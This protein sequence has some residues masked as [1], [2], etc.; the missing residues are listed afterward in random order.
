[1]TT[2]KKTISLV[3]V[4]GGA[5]TTRL[6]VE[7]AATLARAGRSV[8]VIDADTT[9]QGL[10]DYVPGEINPD[11]TRVFAD[12]D[13]LEDALRSL[14]LDT[15]G[16]VAVA[17]AHAPFERLARAQTAGAAQSLGDALA[18]AARDYDHV[19]VDTPA[20]ATNLA[21]AA[22]TE[23]DTVALV[24]PGTDRGLNAT[25]RIRGR[26]ADVGSTYDALIANRA[27]EDLDDAIVTIPESHSRDAT[28]RPAV[29][30]PDD[31]FAPAVASAAETLTGDTL[32]LE[33]PESSLIERF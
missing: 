27:A 15:H 29:L 3:G 7:L 5:G 1:M 26:L 17:P 25:Q 18:A 9:T 21:V 23:T 20:V 31:T 8:A 32:D 11:V 33:Y 4:C 22:V 24:S 14:P 10:A 28:D 13:R 19:L 12:D 6:T 30:D 16:E 2:T